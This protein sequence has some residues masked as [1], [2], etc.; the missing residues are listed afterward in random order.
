MQIQKVQWSIPVVNSIP[1]SLFHSSYFIDVSSYRPEATKSCYFILGT[2]DYL[3]QGTYNLIKLHSRAIFGSFE[4]IK[5]DFWSA[6][7]SSVLIGMQTI[8]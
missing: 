2:G 1:G 8:A 4:V 6:L 5:D 7:V 3:A